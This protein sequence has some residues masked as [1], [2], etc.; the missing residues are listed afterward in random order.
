MLNNDKCFISVISPH[1][2]VDQLKKYNCV[3]LRR[4]YL[5]GRNSVCLYAR[6]QS[7][8]FVRGKWT[9]EHTVSNYYPKRAEN[10]GPTTFLPKY[11]IQHRTASP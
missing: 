2:S 6:K 5:K 1:Q 8:M 7:L 11:H 10:D 3:L 4:V 9:R